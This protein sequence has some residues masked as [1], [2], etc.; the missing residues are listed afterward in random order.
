MLGLFY[1]LVNHMILRLTNIFNMHKI[2]YFLTFIICLNSCS[3]HSNS[4]SSSQ[5]TCSSIEGNWISYV[6]QNELFSLC[7]PN[8]WIKKKWDNINF[9]AV[10]N[11]KKKK[12]F[13]DNFLILIVED[14]SETN[15][16]EIAKTYLNEQITENQE[17]NYQIIGHGVLNIK[18]ELPNYWIDYYVKIDNQLQIYILSTFIKK[19]NNLVMFTF[20]SNIEDIEENKV[21][22]FNVLKSFSM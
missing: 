16:D 12:V 9:A 7:Y 18:N 21:I 19:D 2:F 3:N 20:S 1:Q 17:Y 8:N 6:S 15:L 14:S 22:F 4:E 11:D 13:H 10:R 5:N